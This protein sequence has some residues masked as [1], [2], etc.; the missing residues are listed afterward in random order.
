MPVNTA[1]KIIT[2]TADS[3]QNTPSPLFSMLMTDTRNGDI[4]VYVHKCTLDVKN[5]DKSR[6]A[7][8]LASD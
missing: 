1:F 7:Y 5:I 4:H 2:I 3:S 8:N 6:M